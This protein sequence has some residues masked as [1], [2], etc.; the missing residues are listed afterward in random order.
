MAMD[1]PRGKE[2][3]RRKLI[4]RIIYHCRSC[5]AAIPLI[6]WGLSRLKPAA[7]SVDA[8]N[9]VERYGEARSDG[10]R[11]ARSGN[12]GGGAV[13]VDPG[14]IRKPRG[15]DQF[16]AGRDRSS[17]RRG[18][19]AQQAGHGAGGGG[20]GMAD[21]GSPGQ[22]GESAGDAPDAAT[23]AESHHR[24]SEVRHGAGAN[25]RPIAIRN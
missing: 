7:P 16:S 20:P 12:A 5:L 15:E 18:H 6:T 4:R 25:C 14:G 17:Q 21:Q 22:P 8:G 24:A 3:A 2:V 19:G 1:V 11:C 13:H 23:G 10:A 9:G